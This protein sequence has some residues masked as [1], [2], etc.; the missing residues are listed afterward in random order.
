VSQQPGTQSNNRLRRTALRA[1][2]ELQR[3]AQGCICRKEIAMDLILMTLLG[4]LANELAELLRK[5]RGEKSRRNNEAAA[6]FAQLSAAMAKVV[7]EL[8]ANKIPRISGHEMQTLIYAFAQ[9]T[10]NI[11]GDGESA[12]VK[13][14]LERAAATASTLDSSIQLAQPLVQSEREQ[15]LAVLE[16]ITG[17]CRGLAGVLKGSA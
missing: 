8:R 6:Y 13:A 3:Y 11:F 7:D 2:A 10:K 17:H 4:K 12:T 5:L 16:R 1:G 9:K 15:M 14:S